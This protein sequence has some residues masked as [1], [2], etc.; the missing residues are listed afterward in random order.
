[1]G[2]GSERRVKLTGS[3]DGRSEPVRVLLVDDQPDV[4]ETTALHLERRHDAFEVTVATSGPA[5]LEQLAA[6]TVDCIVSDY[7]MPSMDGLALLR[8]VSTHHGD[9]PFIL[10]TGKGS[11]EIAS[12]AISTGVTDY[13]QKQTTADQYDVLANRI[14]NAVARRRSE[15]AHAETELRYRNLVDTSPDAILV[16]RN[17][18][19]LY[20]NRTL[21][22]FAGIDDISAVYEVDPL[23]YVHPDDRERVRERLLSRP[24]AGDEL[25]WIDWRLRRPDGESRYVESRGAPIAFAGRPA[26]QVVIR[27]VTAHREHERRLEALNAATRDLFLAESR[28]AVA[29]RALAV[30]EETLGESIASVWAY[31]PSTESLVTIAATDDAL[32]LIAADTGIDIDPDAAF[33]TIR[34]MAFPSDS[35]E[36]RVFR[37]GE[38][39]VFEDYGDRDDAVVE[40]IRSAFLFPLESHGMLGVASTEGTAF[41]GW[42]RD[43]LAV[44]CRSVVAALD[45]L[46]E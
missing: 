4:A 33:D 31:D 36:M 25:G 13:L 30:V 26:T 14:E 39:R 24:K 23:S 42:D 21:C 37:E 28:E 35:L 27:D 16:H 40:S 10:F 18:E 7:E 15:R 5:A 45:R 9:L 44:L 6:S 8:E 2:I 3:A 1:M 17:G 12:E 32:D 22:D 43:L 11:E 34:E 46:Y 20:A 29:S 38:A 41:D 19:V